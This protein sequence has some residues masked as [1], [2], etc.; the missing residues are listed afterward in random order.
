MNRFAEETNRK[1][2]WKVYVLISHL[3]NTKA[4]NNPFMFIRWIR[5]L[6]S[7][8]THVLAGMQKQYLS[9]QLVWTDTVQLSWKVIWHSL[10]E[11]S[12]CTPSDPEVPLLRSVLGQ[13]SC[14]SQR[15]KHEVSVTHLFV[16]LGIRG[17][18]STHSW[19][20]REGGR[21]Q[22]KVESPM[23]G[24]DTALG[25]QQ[26]RCTC[27]RN[28]KGTVL[29]TNQWWKLKRLTI[30]SVDKDRQHWKA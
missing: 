17:K 6:Y 23:D 21:C 13:W 4:S 15:G 5:N 20:G 29:D 28:L 11:L 9:A 18:L 3:R 8:V 25:K 22:E 24:H 14:R 16:A 30:L 7:E 27:D 19:W 2:R 12:L 1:V 26:I 10:A